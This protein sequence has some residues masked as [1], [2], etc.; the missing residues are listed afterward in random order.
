MKSKHCSPITNIG[1]G[2]WEEGGDKGKG[3]RR[4]SNQTLSGKPLLFHKS[5]DPTSI[6]YSGKTTS[7]RDSKSAMDQ[8]G[9][10][11][12]CGQ[13]TALKTQ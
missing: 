8:F 1:R 7:Q 5:S 6:S 11:L 12:D 9:K 4:E 2:L 10:K 3:R 13:C